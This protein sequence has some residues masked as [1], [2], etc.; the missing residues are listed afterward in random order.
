M[1]KDH[2]DL[3]FSLKERRVS[4]RIQRIRGFFLMFFDHEVLVS[5]PRDT[6]VSSRLL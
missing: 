6:R 2:E 5:S 1:V 4:S 3:V